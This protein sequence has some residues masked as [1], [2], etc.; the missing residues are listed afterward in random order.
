MHDFTV[1]VLPGAFASSVTTTLD[2]LGAAGALAHSAGAVPPRWRLCSPDGGRLALQGPV[3]IDTQRLPI[4]SRS[5]RSIWL[6]PGLGLATPGQVRR[7]L[8]APGIRPVLAALRRHVGAGGQVAASCSAVFLLGAAGLLARRRATI[9]WWHAP[10][11][12]ALVP[13]CRVDPDRM[14]CA[15]GPVT[16][17]G[18]AFAQI[19]LTI[20]LVRDRCGSALADRVSR[21][22]LIDG[23]Q[24]QAPFILPDVLAGGHELVARLTARI[25]AALPD[26][27][28][29][30]ELAREMR[31]SERTLS[32]HVHAA[33]GRSTRSLVRMV[34]L[35]RARQLLATT[36]LPVDRVA[37]A[38]GYRDTT[39]L[40]RLLKKLAGATP[41]RL[42]Q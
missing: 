33:T 17:A 15:D 28:A 7:Y 8:D 21:M 6:L 34:R 18:A 20:Q 36:R 13:D 24:S 25:E 39:A 4:R 16:T 32:R 38:V 40:R 27:P 5:D 29:V 10:L 31:M 12:Q 30:A 3:G 23:R 2:I 11:L 26:P 19:D 37:A 22:L 41:S 42:R 1:V 14:V 9:S 35:Q